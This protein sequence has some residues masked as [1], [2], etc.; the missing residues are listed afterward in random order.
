MIDFKTG[1]I[2]VEACN[3]NEEEVDVKTYK[4]LGTVF[5]SQL[6]S[7]RI[8]NA[9]VS[10]VTKE[11][12]CWGTLNATFNKFLLRVILSFSFMCLF[13]GLSMKEKNSISNIVKL[14]SEITGAWF[15]NLCS[16]WKKPVIHNTK[17][18]IYLTHF[19]ENSLLYLQVS[20]I[21]HKHGK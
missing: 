9:L 16:L 3:I 4:Y 7:K 15:N 18:I 10:G 14:C 2:I 1:W 13:S 17:G 21:M 5:D 20:I 11:F 19:P 8:M 6:K 12:T